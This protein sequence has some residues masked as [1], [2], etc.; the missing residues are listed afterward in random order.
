M[1]N[2]ELSTEEQ[3]LLE[4]MIGIFAYD[5]GSVNS[6]IKNERRRSEV[7][8][9]LED[10]SDNHPDRFRVLLAKFIRENFL[11]DEALDMHYGLED[12]AIFFRWLD[13]DMGFS[14]F[15]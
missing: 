2:E 14:A 10:Q 7:I 11:S 5:E 15:V 3:S 8:A 9:W 6:G 13:R 1:E 12:V 4:D